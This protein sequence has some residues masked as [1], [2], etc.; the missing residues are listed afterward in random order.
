MSFA[1]EFRKIARQMNWAFIPVEHFLDA[2]C[3]ILSLLQSLI[4]LLTH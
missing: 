4:W 3:A 1:E 2:V